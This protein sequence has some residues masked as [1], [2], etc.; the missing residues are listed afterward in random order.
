MAVDVEM[1]RSKG[2]AD[3]LIQVLADERDA[4]L[5]RQAANALCDL[6]ERAV[7]P[8]IRALRSRDEQLRDAVGD[9]L[10]EMDRSILQN[11][12]LSFEEQEVSLCDFDCAGPILDIGGGGA[13]IIGLWKGSQV[14][15]IDRSR[16]ELEE[17]PDGP[18]KVLMDAR[19]L[20]FLNDSFAVATAFY[21]LMYMQASD[22][23]LVFREVLRILRPG[24]RFLVWDAVIPAG[25]RDGKEL[26]IFPLAIKFPDG[27]QILRGYGILWPEEEQN[28]AY[29]LSLARAVGFQVVTKAEQGRALFFELQKPPL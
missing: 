1:L 15:A 22:H 8:L 9:V 25:P 19:E 23:E 11:L 14:V 12:A 4:S 17:A 10:H 7:K 5:R 6:G 27:E 18:L 3:A 16:R 21:S 13:G 28:L 26:A 24:G 29:Y 2:D 20:K